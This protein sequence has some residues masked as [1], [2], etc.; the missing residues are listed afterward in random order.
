MATV[1]TADWITATATGVAAIGTVA[2]VILA[3]WLQVWKEWRRRPQLSLM[4]RQLNH[5]F[6]SDGF[7]GEVEVIVTNKAD[8]G[9]AREVEVLFTAYAME[10]TEQYPPTFRDQPLHWRNHGGFKIDIPPGVE[11]RCVILNAGDPHTIYEQAGFDL[12]ELAARDDD[13]GAEIYHTAV[14]AFAGSARVPGE[15][16]WIEQDVPY[17]LWLVLTGSDVPA[18]VYRAEINATVRTA[19]VF[20]EWTQLP[21]KRDAV[22]PT[23]IVLAS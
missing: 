2:A 13:E 22:E 9:T 12:S 19:G 6:S 14:G 1:T 20:V 11:R 23:G 8:R 18:K 10:D 15:I 17:E 4:A 3:L 21:E 7:Y 16:R 5:G